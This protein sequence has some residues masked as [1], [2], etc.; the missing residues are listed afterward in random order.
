MSYTVIAD[1]SI[2]KQQAG[3]IVLFEEHSQVEYVWFSEILNHIFPI[4]IEG[5]AYNA[6]QTKGNNKKV[7]QANT[8]ATLESKVRAA[9]KSNAKGGSLAQNG[10][11]GVTS[12]NEASERGKI[13]RLQSDNGKYEVM[14]NTS[15]L[16]A[17][18]KSVQNDTNVPDLETSKTS[19]MFPARSGISCKDWTEI[20]AL[21]PIAEPAG[22]NAIV[23]NTR[24]MATSVAK[25]TR[26]TVEERNKLKT[27]SETFNQNN[28]PDDVKAQ[29]KDRAAKKLIARSD[30]FELVDGNWKPRTCCN[31]F[32][33]EATGT[34]GTVGTQRSVR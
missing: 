12:M 24:N 22:T 4:F 33:R 19:R 25:L 17:Y 13:W 10:S 28:L 14:C 26:A 23:T 32:T 18:I 31:E 16:G 15:N 7:L 9:V 6:L 5:G 30:I 1:G 29:Y 34:S 21:A 2:L 3:I 27:R 11:P 20:L 8:L